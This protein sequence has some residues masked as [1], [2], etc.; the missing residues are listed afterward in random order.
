[1]EKRSLPA[2]AHTASLWLPLLPLSFLLALGLLDQLGPDPGKELVHELGLWSLQLLLLTLA[3]TPLNRFTQWQ[4][5][6]MRRRLGLYALAYALLHVLCYALFYLGFDIGILAKE[7]V[8]RPY[9]V[10]GASALV[11]LAALGIT[12]SRRWQQR[13]GRRWRTLHRLVYPAAILVIVHFAWQ[14]KSGFG[15]AP[16]Y[17]LVFVG[18]MA[19]RWGLR[20]SFAKD[21]T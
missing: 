6:P 19:A 16:W 4:W 7:L 3:I 20:A 15:N 14:V 11:I 17:A 12:S 21:R 1:M 9:I 18:V 10:V 5:L 13:L 2:I 8:K